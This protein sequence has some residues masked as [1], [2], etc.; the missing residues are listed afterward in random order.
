MDQLELRQPAV[1][2]RLR[3]LRDAS[4]VEVGID[5]QR[6]I[7]RVRPEPLRAIDDWLAPY[8]AMWAAGLDDLERHLD[9][10]KD[11]G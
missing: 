7:Y 10:M 3:I 4:R 2:E 11:D 1:S 5:A 6:R 8:R 9:T